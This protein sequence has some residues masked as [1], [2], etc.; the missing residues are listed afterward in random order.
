[1][2]REEWLQ[3]LRKQGQFEGE[4]ALVPGQGLAAFISA[5]A[6]ALAQTDYEEAIRNLEYAVDDPYQNMPYLQI[7]DEEALH[8]LLGLLS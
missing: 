4:T 8:R 1:M 7:A 3:S 2:G 5:V 6:Y